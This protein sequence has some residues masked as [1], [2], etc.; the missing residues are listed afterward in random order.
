M[1]SD[2]NLVAYCGLYC[3]SCR[4]YLNGDCLGCQKNNKASWCKVRICCLENRYLSCADCEKNKNSEDCKKLNN[5][6][7]KVFSLIFSSD[8]NGCI[9][10]IKN[11]GYEKY[12]DEMSIKKVMAIKRK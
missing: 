12:A 4:K 3:G 8:R 11:I 2:K 7:S 10:R 1:N 6:V 5:F 9:K